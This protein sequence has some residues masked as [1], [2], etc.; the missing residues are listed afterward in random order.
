MRRSNTAGIAGI[1]LIG[2]VALSLSVIPGHAQELSDRSVKTIM[3][4]AWSY[5]PSKFTPP[6]GKTIHI[7]KKNREKMTVPV[8]KGREVIKVA[9]LT[10]HAQICN[11]PE[12]QV[13]NYR[14]LMSR[15]QKS[16]KWSKQQIVYI[17]QLHLTTVMMLVGKLQVVEQKGDKKVVIK[18]GK[19]AVKT[20]T[21]E[22]RSKVKELI[23]AYV[24]SGPDLKPLTSTGSVKPAKN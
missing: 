9:R 10:A 20:C 14:S 2:L 16:K 13:K 7:D 21:D 3:N 23:T 15:E 4:Y 17:N 18:E 1:S 11:L 19:P 22:Q 6:S 8:D 12:E 24:A 5:T